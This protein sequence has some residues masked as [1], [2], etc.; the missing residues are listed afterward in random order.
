[1][2]CCGG[3]ALAYC[4]KVLHEADVEKKLVAVISQDK[5]VAVQQSAALALAVMADD[6]RSRDAIRKCG[7]S[8]KHTYSII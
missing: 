6:D 7:A 3:C 1:M 2:C 8:F 4:R 5:S